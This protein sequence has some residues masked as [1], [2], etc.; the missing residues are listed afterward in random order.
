MAGITK[1]I[2]KC[3]ENVQKNKDVRFLVF[4][5]LLIIGIVTTILFLVFFSK[6]YTYNK[7]FG[8]AKPPEMSANHN[9]ET[10]F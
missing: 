3:K 5:I 1:C 6:A 4:L 8:P 10:F 2:K 7:N 9:I